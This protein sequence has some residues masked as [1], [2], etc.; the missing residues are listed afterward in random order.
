MRLWLLAGLCALLAGCASSDDM[1]VAA[2]LDGAPNVPE[3]AAGARCER[4][5]RDLRVEADKRAEG[6]E[7][8][9]SLA[10]YAA[11]LSASEAAKAGAL[12]RAAAALIEGC[13]DAPQPRLSAA[14]SATA[15]PA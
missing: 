5:A 13:G 14:E 8:G 3:R 2:R 4:L 1:G 6:P 15:R 10:E 11:R 9:E 7:A 12:K